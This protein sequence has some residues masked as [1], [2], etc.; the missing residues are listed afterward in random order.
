MALWVSPSQG[1]HCWGCAEAQR[2]QE[3]RTPLVLVLLWTLPSWDPS[4]CGSEVFSQGVRVWLHMAP[5]CGGTESQP[6]APPALSKELL[7]GPLA[8]RQ[9]LCDW[10]AAEVR[11]ESVKGLA[12]QKSRE[13]LART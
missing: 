6:F 5:P 9:A 4:P 10:A 3:S 13:G 7:G 11:P 1:P 12:A 2:G 8:P